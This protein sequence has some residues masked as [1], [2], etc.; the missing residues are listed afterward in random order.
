VLWLKENA[1]MTAFEVEKSTTIDSGIRRFRNL[2]AATPRQQIEAYILIPDHREEEA[3]KKIGSLAN[4]KEGLHERIQY[5]K[6]SD[7]KNQKS[8]DLENI[9]QK[10]V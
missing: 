10:V 2:F 5:I 7:I 3:I 4:R 6:F 1:I 9:A 8:I